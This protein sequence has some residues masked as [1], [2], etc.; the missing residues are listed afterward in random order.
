MQKQKRIL[1]CPLDWGLGHA[2]RCIPIIRLLLKKNAK[3]IIAADGRP[4]ELLK[5]EFPELQFIQLKGYSIN[6]PAS[7]AM[8][9]KMLFSLPKIMKGIK[10][11]HTQLEKIIDEYN[12]DIVISDNRYGCWNKKVKSVFITHQLMIKAPFGE[13]ILHRKVLNFIKNYDECWIPD[14]A[15]LQNLSGDLAHKNPIPE[16]TYFI[17]PLSRFDSKNALSVS[18]ETINSEAKSFDIMAIISGPEPQRGMLKYMLMQK[19]QETN[20]RCLIICGE[21][22]SKW[23]IEL[24]ENLS[25]KSHLGA[26][27]MQEAILNSK[28]ILARS[29]YSTIMDLAMLGKK[30][31]FIPTP[32]QT[33]Q[34]YLAKLFSERMIAYSQSQ[35]AFQLEKAIEASKNYKGF[36]IIETSGEFEKRIE[37]LLL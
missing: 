14:Y 26:D 15:G 3:V 36:E 12:I 23:E 4:L 13:N 8:I 19:L 34:E 16:N 7:D 28:L 17:G 6:Y 35:S 10:E 30:V 2:T 21:T 37:Q 20:Y 24:N 11:E 33:E 9:L 32:G 25:M 1:I 22:E 27:E 29:G 18:K 5:Q 31:I